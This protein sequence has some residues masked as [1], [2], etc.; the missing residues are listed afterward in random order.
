MTDSSVHKVLL[1]LSLLVVLIITVQ[2]QNLWTAAP[3]NLLRPN[4]PGERW[5]EIYRPQRLWPGRPLLLPPV[6]YDY[7]YAGKLTVTRVDDVKAAC[8]RAAY[9]RGTPMGCARVPAP[10]HEEC[11]IFLLPDDLIL[12]M[13]YDPDHIYRH[14]IGHCNGWVHTTPLT[15]TNPMAR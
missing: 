11:E 5:P 13:G 2:A 15:T 6:E 7:P 3:G 1:S 12:A 10:G 14:E 4:M 8:P 9:G